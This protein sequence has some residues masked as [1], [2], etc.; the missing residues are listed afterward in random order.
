MP[1]SMLVAR[2]TSHAACGG[3]GGG[4]GE[5]VTGGDA[6]GKASVASMDATSTELNATRLI[7]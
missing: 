2:A 4:E 1:F 6:G 3:V 7:A 5:G